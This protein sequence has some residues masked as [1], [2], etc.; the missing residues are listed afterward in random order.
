MNHFSHADEDGRK[1]VKRQKTRVASL[2]TQ[3]KAPAQIRPGCLDAL[4]FE[5]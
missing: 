3:A 2:A 5:S 4:R 1:L